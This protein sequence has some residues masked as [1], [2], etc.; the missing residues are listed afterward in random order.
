M[1]DTGAITRCAV[2]QGG[3]DEGQAQAGQPLHEDQGAVLLQLRPRPADRGV[4]RQL[5]SRRAVCAIYTTID[6][7]SSA[8]RS[9]RS[10][11]TLNEPTDPA[12]RDRGDQPAQRRDPRHGVGAA[13]HAA[14]AVQPRRAGP[15]PG[16][17]RRSRRSSSRRRSAAASTR[18]RR[19]TCRRRSPISRIR[20]SEPWSPKTYDN[21]YYGPSSL[22]APRFAR[23]T[24]STRGLTLDLGPESIVKHGARDG[25]P[26]PAQAGGLDRPRLERRVGAGHGVRVRDACRRRRLPRADGDPPG[27]ASRTAAIDRS[28]GWGTPQ[29]KRVIPDGV[30][31]QVTRILEEN[32]LDGTGTRALLR[33]PGRGEDRNDRRPH[34]RLV[35]GLHAARSPTAVWV[36]YPN[37]TI[38]MTSVHGIAVSGGS[39]PAIIWNLFMS[40][41]LRERRRAD[42]PLPKAAGRLASVAREVPVPG[43]HVQDGDRTRPRRTRP[44]RTPS[45]DTSGPP[46]TVTVPRRAATAARRAAAARTSL[47]RPRA[48]TEPLTATST[49]ALDRAHAPAGVTAAAARV[50]RRSRVTRAP[51]PPPRSRPGVG[52]SRPSG[53]SPSPRR[54]PDSSPLSPDHAGGDTSWSWLYLGAIVGVVR[55]LPRR[56][57]SARTAERPRSPQ[58]W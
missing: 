31:Y 50:A 27:R 44:R 40:R 53:L 56:A 9:R 18:T 22:T 6:P 35:R 19:R 10:A 11:T 39:F 36:G 20:H 37:A 42:L 52:T 5:R 28:A 54:I 7:R 49:S 23:T 32:L 1:R 3:R 29:R 8:A 34:R 14:D 13:G 21:T 17:A 46:V 45:R 41:A 47:R 4:R 2:P 51:C 58:C 43:R 16:R 55:P 30:A 57:R 25:R 33:P 24:P 12:V 26:L 38:E 48:A 15:P